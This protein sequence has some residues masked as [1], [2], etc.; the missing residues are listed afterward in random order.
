MRGWGVG[1]KRVGRVCERV[2]HKVY[3]YAKVCRKVCCKGGYDDTHLVNAFEGCVRGYMR[4]NMR[5]Y[6]TMP[7]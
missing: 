2:C 5:G 1:G 6:M 7:G 4:R 3:V